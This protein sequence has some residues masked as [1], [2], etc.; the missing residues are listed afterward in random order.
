MRKDLQMLNKEELIKITNDV[1]EIIKSS[2]L[3]PY[4]GV[5]A[6]DILKSPF[7][8]FLVGYM[9]AEKERERKPSQLNG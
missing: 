9:I 3:Y 2:H 7:L 4:E 5:S 1:C 8:T 6:V